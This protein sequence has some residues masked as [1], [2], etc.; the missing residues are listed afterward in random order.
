MSTINH[1][2]LSEL[3]D[4][5]SN[6]I[7]TSFSNQTF[8]IIADV[9]NHTYKPQ[10]DYHYFDLVEKE[11]NSNDINAKISAKAW[12]KGSKRIEYFEKVTGQK[13]TNKI[14]VLI[15]VKVTFHKKYGLSLELIEIDLS[16]TIGQLEQQ[17]QATL[18]KL[19]SDNDFITQI[20]EKYVTKNNQLTLPQV[21]Q[22]IAIISSQTTAGIED[23][24]DTLQKNTFKYCFWIDDYYSFVQGTSNAKQ[25]ILKLIEVFE[26]KKKYD[27][28]VIVRGGGAQTDFL[29][30]DDYN[31]GKAVAKFP[32][33]IITGIGHQ[34]NESIT[35]LMANTQ[36]INPAQAAAFIIAHNRTF[37]ES[38]LKIQKEIVIKSQQ[39]FSINYQHLSSLNINF[40]TNARK[41]LTNNKDSLT[42]LQQLTVNKSKS[43]VFNNKN[44]L[45]NLSS[46]IIS[47]P[48]IVVYNRLN[49]LDNV[50][51]NLKFYVTKFLKFQRGYLGHNETVI[52][53]MS[54]FNILRKGFA[55]IKIDDKV[56]SNAKDIKIGEDIE[57]ILSDIQLKTT[58]KQNKDY[59]GTEFNL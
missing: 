55:I 7:E 26:S 11:P 40:A 6:V 2:K 20:G 43:I 31:L 59:N 58:V 30:F 19:V 18:K 13:F 17:R 36:A 25:I 5:I 50:V 21:I 16:F 38:I 54:P 9:T 44:Q 22:R 56:I 47:K 53:L 14:N 8:W 10:K 37:E 45:I 4:I 49:D 42:E 1:L 41:L 48:K 3:N 23:F 52:K 27:A 35:D 28:V 57:V 39:L 33:P 51:S 46:E 29:I 24:K 32:I 34:R 12:G 15:Q